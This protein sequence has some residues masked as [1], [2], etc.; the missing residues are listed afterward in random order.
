[1]I[2]IPKSTSVGHL[3]ENLASL[4]LDLSPDDLAALDKQFPPPSHAEPLDML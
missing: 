3:D 2:V 4:E 1:M